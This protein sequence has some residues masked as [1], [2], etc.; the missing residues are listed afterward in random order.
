MNF[1]FSRRTDLALAALHALSRAPKG[2]RTRAELARETGTT[3]SFLPQVMGPLIKAGWVG[4]DR[5]PG[6]GYRLTETARS[7]RI[8][9]L[10]ELFEGPTIDGR[11]VL[12]DDRCPESACAVHAAWA[13]A[14]R[15]LVK[16]L[17]DV[18]VL[19][20]QGGKR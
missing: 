13:D 19:G 6:G 11:C 2:K 1:E 16:G 18:Q 9:E 10:I 17:E 15:V 8:L 20:A 4:S 3:T 14:R 12:R 7:A 5:G